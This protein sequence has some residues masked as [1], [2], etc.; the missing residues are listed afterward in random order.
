MTLLPTVFRSALKLVEIFMSNK[1]RPGVSRTEKT[2]NSLKRVNVCVNISVE[3]TLLE[4]I[5]C[6]PLFTVIKTSSI[7]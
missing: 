6:A 5:I 2:L 4:E 3:H 1:N 7:F